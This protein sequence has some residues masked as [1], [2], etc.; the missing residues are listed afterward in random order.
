MLQ[1]QQTHQQLMQQRGPEKV[2]HVNDEKTCS[3]KTRENWKHQHT[4]YLSFLC[5]VLA[6]FGEEVGEDVPT[7][8]GHMDQRT[9]F[10]QAKAR[11]YSQNQGYGL[12]HQRPLP[13]V[14]PDDK[15]TQDCLDLGTEES[16]Q[17]GGAGQ[18]S[19]KSSSRRL[20]FTFRKLWLNKLKCV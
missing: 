8:A 1:K 13:Q 6:V 16:G 9:L 4:R 18:R 20:S 7:A 17:W 11:C 19:N 5:L 14:T 12:D 10:T 2:K 15:P 3:S